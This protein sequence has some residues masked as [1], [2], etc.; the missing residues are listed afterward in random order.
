MNE[1]ISPNGKLD[2]KIWILSILAAIVLMGM[3]GAGWLYTDLSSRVSLLREADAQHIER[4][5]R[6]EE[7]YKSIKDSLERIEKRLEHR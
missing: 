4:I 7:Q 3:S 1:I 6:V 2:W 5:T